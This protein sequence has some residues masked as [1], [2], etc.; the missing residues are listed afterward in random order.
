MAFY[1]QVGPGYMAT[2]RLRRESGYMYKATIGLCTWSLWDWVQDSI[3]GHHHMA[4][5]GNHRRPPLTWGMR[6]QWAW[7]GG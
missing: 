4:T 7:V 1:L 5:T 2:M 3:G 6:P